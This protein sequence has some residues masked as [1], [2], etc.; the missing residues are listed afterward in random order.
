MDTIIVDC[1]IVVLASFIISILVSACIEDCRKSGIP[2]MGIKIVT[3]IILIIGVII[4]IV[5]H[6]FV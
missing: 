5:D 4:S 1:G 3:I 6:I 2:V